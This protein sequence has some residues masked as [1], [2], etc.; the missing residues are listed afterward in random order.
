MADA[1]KKTYLVT[2]KPKDVRPD[3]ERDKLE[4]FR[5]RAPS[6]KIFLNARALARG[7]V[8]PP[9]VMNDE[10]GYDVDRYEAQ[11]LGLPERARQNHAP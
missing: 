6:T 1:Q 8:A 9:E 7:Y 2:F 3:R 10:I 11:R 4:I 5:E